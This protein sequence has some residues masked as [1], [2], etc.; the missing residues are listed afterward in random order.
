MHRYLKKMQKIENVVCEKAA[1]SSRPNMSVITVMKMIGSR[2]YTG[3]ALRSNKN[4]LAGIDLTQV[5]VKVNV[6]TLSWR[7]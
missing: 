6:L 7:T 4:D 2:I 3:P 5:P 1:I